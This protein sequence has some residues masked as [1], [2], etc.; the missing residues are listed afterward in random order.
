MRSFVKRHKEYKRR[1]TYMFADR[2][3]EI[4]LLRLRRQNE[5]LYENLWDE[6][7]QR[8]SNE[9]ASAQRRV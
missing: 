7:V 5:R 4:E 9:E 6:S 2:D 3:D 8:Y 1:G